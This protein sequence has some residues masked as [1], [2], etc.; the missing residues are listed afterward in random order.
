MS[1]FL[2]ESNISQTSCFCCAG[3][4]ETGGVFCRERGTSRSVI[5]FFGQHESAE[6]LIPVSIASCLAHTQESSEP[7]AEDVDDDTEGG[8]EFDEHTQM[9]DQWVLDFSRY[10]VATNHLITQSHQNL[11]QPVETRGAASK[12][13]VAA[14]LSDTIN[15]PWV[16]QI[17]LQDHF[18]ATTRKGTN[19]LL[20]VNT[21]IA[22][23]LGSD[24]LM[25]HVKS[26]PRFFGHFIKKLNVRNGRL[27]N[28]DIALLQSERV[29]LL[30]GGAGKTSNPGIIGPYLAQV[31]QLISTHSGSTASNQFLEYLKKT[32]PVAYHCLETVVTQEVLQRDYG[33]VLQVPI[34]V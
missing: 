21:E 30:S 1:T 28:T 20:V 34:P 22:S 33:L 3:L 12:S 7:T 18:S 25:V 6:L 2:N 16:D 27:E 4:G 26:D 23:W 13:L 29:V 5:P 32:T 10:A 24:L 8:V 11:V 14:V 9:A 17:E 19:I 15:F 31:Y